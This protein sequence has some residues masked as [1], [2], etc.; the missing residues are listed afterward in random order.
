[1]ELRVLPA[2][3]SGLAPAPPHDAQLIALTLHAL[4]EGAKGLMLKIR[5]RAIEHFM[6]FTEN[7]KVWVSNPS[8]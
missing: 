6:G 5:V 7:A 4:D 3:A 8:S 2:V 1:V